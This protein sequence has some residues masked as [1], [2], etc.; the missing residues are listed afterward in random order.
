MVL[1][2]DIFAYRSKDL[3]ERLKEKSVLA[4]VERFHKLLQMGDVSD[5]RQDVTWMDNLRFECLT[6]L[7]DKR[8]HYRVENEVFI[9]HKLSTSEG[10]DGA[11]E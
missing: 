6:V 5:Y 1:Q 7:S 11:D 2:V 4:I 8:H 10:S 3:C 9:V